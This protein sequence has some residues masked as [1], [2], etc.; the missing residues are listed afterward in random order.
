LRF[1]SKCIQEAKKFSRQIII[2]IS[3]CFF[4]GEKENQNLLNLTFAN[5]LDCFFILYKYYKNTL[6]SPYRH[7]SR[8]SSKRKNFWHSTS[9]YLGYLFL[10]KKTEYV[11]FLDADEICNGDMFKKWLDK[12]EYKNFNAFRFAYYYYFKKSSLRAKDYLQCGLM[13]KNNLPPLILLESGERFKTFNNIT[14]KKKPVVFG[15]NNLPMIHHYSW[16]RTK[17]EMLKKSKSWGHYNDKNWNKLIEEEFLKNKNKDFFHNLS[18]EKKEIFF[19]PLKI[20][21]KNKKNKK[22]FKHVLKVKKED[23]FKKELEITHNL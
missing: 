4:D 23:V 6:Y 14:G 21:Y 2:P 13:M 15:N 3:D 9:R 16:V 11:L 7:C 10:D 5:H 17:K 22:I 18:L 8:D 19:D 12:Y 20:N 1:I